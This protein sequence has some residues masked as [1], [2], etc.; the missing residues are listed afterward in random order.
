MKLFVKQGKTS[1][2]LFF[3]VKDSSSSTGAYKTGLDNTK[4]AI[5][6]SRE[7]DGNA[8]STVVSLSAGTRGTWSSGGLVEKDATHSK[9]EYEFGAPNAAFAAG[10]GIVTF[11][12]QDAGSNNIVPLGIEV[13]LVPWDPDD[14]VH[15]GL[16][17]LPNAAAGA[18][19][20]LPINGTNAGNIVYS[21]TITYNGDITHNGH[22]AYTFGVDITDDG[23][24]V[25]ALSVEA[26]STQSAVRIDGS[27][28]N[29]TVLINA[30]NGGEALKL[31]GSSGNN[32]VNVTGSTSPISIAGKVILLGGLQGLPG[33]APSAGVELKPYGISTDIYF[34]IPLANAVGLALNSDWAPVSGDVLIIQDGGNVANATNLP[35]IMH[36]SLAA[37]KPIWK[38]TLTAGEMTAKKI[39]VVIMDASNPPLVKPL[40][41]DIQTYGDPS[42]EF[43]P[44]S[45]T[46]QKNTAFNGFQFV[47]T[48]NAQHRPATG[49]TVT[50]T[51]SIDGAG[52]SACANAV[53][54]ISNGAYKINLA[55]GDLNGANIL[56]RFT[57]T[58]CD[59]R[60]ISVFTQ[61]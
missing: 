27:I 41:L 17:S 7:D 5:A 9:G 15:L 48:D 24:H 10:S 52:F 57:A 45:L 44:V 55:A 35:T 18:G 51:R 3:K 34:S 26:F 8:G 21:G 22:E 13:Q 6:Y 1:K 30:S 56:F 4:F 53:V 23:S 12:I 54:E 42:A 37:Q 33:S 25:A 58:G 43:V 11:N 31:V 47:M 40:Y 61:S 49:K 36:N 19:G 29:P 59:D 28:T 20:G 39:V 60:L 14:G 38:L 50:A 46:V 2:R 32:V 16:S